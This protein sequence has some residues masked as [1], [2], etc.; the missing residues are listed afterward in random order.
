MRKEY[1]FSKG[2][3]GKYAGRIKPGDTDP[4]NMKVRVTMYLDADIV[5]HFKTLAAA[6]DAAGYQTLINHTLRQAM[7]SGQGEAGGDFSGL[8]DNSRFIQAVAERVARLTENPT[9][10]G[11]ES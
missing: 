4:R 6:P 3:R 2:E 9:S 10:G 1:D 11:Q 7:E 8:L 5:E